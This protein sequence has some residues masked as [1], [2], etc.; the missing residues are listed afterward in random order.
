MNAEKQE[1]LVSFT[2]ALPR[3]ADQKDT[4]TSEPDPQKSVSLHLPESAP[5][6]AGID[7]DL[8]GDLQG[9]AR[10]LQSELWTLR[11]KHN[12]MGEEL[13][14]ER[15]ESE[16]TRA[17]LTSAR[18]EMRTVREE[19]AVVKASL[20]SPRGGP[21]P[22]PSRPSPSSRPHLDE[23]QPP[24]MAWASANSDMGG[25]GAFAPRA[26]P[27]S[28]LSQPNLYHAPSAALSSGSASVGDTVLAAANFIQMLATQVKKQKDDRF[29]D[30][31][32]HSAL[33]EDAPE[34][35]GQLPGS[36]GEAYRD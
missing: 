4:A 28:V 30:L 13:A 9:Q 12:E 22:S 6:A 32:A 15:R 5:R 16:L 25:K 27:G 11:E 10:D 1:K 35:P 20:V 7:P 14:Q 19:L 17:E 26:G 31:T 21:A 3:G 18:E 34:L 8:L 29:S 36:T 33:P 24:H 23:A 2:D